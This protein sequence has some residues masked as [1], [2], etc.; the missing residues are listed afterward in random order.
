MQSSNTFVRWLCP[1]LGLLFLTLAPSAG[2]Q[3]NP[4][5]VR[6]SQ[7]YGGG[8]NNDAVLHSDFIEL[9]NAAPEPVNL[10]GWSLQYAAKE[11]A[12]WSVTPLGDVTIAGFGYRLVIAAATPE[13]L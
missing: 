2:A 11:G 13:Q 12:N 8:G 5:L 4:P 9:F 3:S 6:I 7:I 1:L 10:N